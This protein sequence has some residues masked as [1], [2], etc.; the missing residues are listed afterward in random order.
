[1]LLLLQ[2]DRSTLA[3]VTAL[4]PGGALPT[5]SVIEGRSDAV[6]LQA[7]CDGEITWQHLED[8]KRAGARAML[9]L[10]VEQMLA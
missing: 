7:V 5:I 4:L 1:R 10:P 9:V 6:A 3:D 2:A 8:L